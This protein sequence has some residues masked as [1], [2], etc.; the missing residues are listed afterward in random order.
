MRYEL[1]DDEWATVKPM[2]PNKPPR[3]RAMMRLSSS[4]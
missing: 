3:H 1:A 4:A 2:L